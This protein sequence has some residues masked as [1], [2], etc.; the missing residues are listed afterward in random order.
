M[1]K[2]KDVVGYLSKLAPEISHLY[3]ISIPGEKATLTSAETAAAAKSAGIEAS[4]ATGL[5]SA[6]QAIA[7]NHPSAR[8][9][10]CGSLYMA[11]HVLREDANS[12]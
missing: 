12:P 4:E 7:E 11:G 2:T 1:L 5:L 8:I 6:L 9:L 3:A 10:V